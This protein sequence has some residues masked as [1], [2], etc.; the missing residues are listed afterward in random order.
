MG[1]IINQ[2]KNKQDKFQ[3]PVLE[4]LPKQHPIPLPLITGIFTAADT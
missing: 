4:H 3:A 2:Q 1:G